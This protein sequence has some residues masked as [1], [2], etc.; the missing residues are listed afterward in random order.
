[1]GPGGLHVA[2]ARGA[3]RARDDGRGHQRAAVLGAA[4]SSRSAPPRHAGIGVAARA[5]P[6]RA[7]AL[8]DQ[9]G[10]QLRKRPRRTRPDQGDAIMELRRRGLPCSCTLVT[11]S[12]SST[13]HSVHWHISLS[14]V[15]QCDLPDPNVTVHYVLTREIYSAETTVWLEARGTLLQI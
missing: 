2:V 8:P 14:D 6:A 10:P 12:P 9:V 5:V 13:A 15:G 7:C 4:L 11:S 3:P 1:M